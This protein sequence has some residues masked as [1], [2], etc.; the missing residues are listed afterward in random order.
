[1]WQRKG[2]CQ[3][4]VQP[5]SLSRTNSFLWINPVLLERY[6]TLFKAPPLLAP[7]QW[8]LCLNMSFGGGKPC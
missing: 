6:Y 1:V 3:L 8:G 5:P 7:L 2:R 4:T